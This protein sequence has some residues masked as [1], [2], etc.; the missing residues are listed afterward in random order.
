[1]RPQTQNPIYTLFA[2]EFVQ[3]SALLTA[4]PPVPR[5]GANSR[6]SRTVEALFTRYDEDRYPSAYK[7]DNAS[8]VVLL[9]CTRFM[10]KNRRRGRFQRTGVQPSSRQRTSWL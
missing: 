6:P 10:V 9:G 8:G 1:M 3:L 2:A 7:H 4:I 5:N